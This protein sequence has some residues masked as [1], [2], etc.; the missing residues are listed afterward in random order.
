M[1]GKLRITAAV[2]IT[3]RHE[4]GQAQTAPG[5]ARHT[6][7]HAYS[8]CG[9]QHHTR[10]LHTSSH[11]LQ[12]LQ[13]AAVTNAGAMPASPGPQSAVRHDGGTSSGA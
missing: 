11:C 10:A 1:E 2:Q 7:A 4:P 3:Q 5:P 8:S 13:Q 6:L 9:A 12:Q